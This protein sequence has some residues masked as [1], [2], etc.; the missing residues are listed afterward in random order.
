MPISE[1]E[2]IA[3]LPVERQEAIK[4]R[5]SEMIAEVASLREIREARERMPQDGNVPV[6]ESLADVE[7]STIL[8]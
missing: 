7:P 2:I 5:T 3:K 1:D 6:A 4:R 8:P